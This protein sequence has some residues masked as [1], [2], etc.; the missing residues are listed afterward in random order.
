MEYLQS[1][2][3]IRTGRAEI[4]D[5]IAQYENI[6][7]LEY[8]AMGSSGWSPPAK[9][10]QKLSTVI[11][12]IDNHKYGSIL[13]FE[14]LRKKLLEKVTKLGL[15]IDDLEIMITCGANQAFVN[16]ILCL[17]DNDDKAVLLA[18]YYFSHKLALQ[19]AGVQVHVCPFIKSSLL[20]DMN[21][22]EIILKEQ[23][24]KVCVLTNPN[25]PSG[26]V[27]DKEFLQQFITLCKK[28]NTWIVADSTYFE[29]VYED[30]YVKHIWPCSKIFDYEKIIHHSSFSKNFAM[31]GWRVGFM[32]FPKFL[33]DDMRKIQDT[34][35]T[36]TSIFSE[37]LA[38]FALEVDEEALLKE[39]KSWV[40]SK[41]EGLETIRAELW[42][43]L[44]PYG[45]I[46]PSGSFYY[47]VPI[48]GIV[49]E[50]KAVDILAHQFKILVMPGKVFGAPGYLRVSFGSAKSTAVK[51]L[52]QGLKY[53]KDLTM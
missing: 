13:G 7:D 32:L 37:K 9:A 14:P 16:S 30:S 52:E 40:K 20:P 5:I 21:Q 11:N 3:V 45:V 8:L 44:A 28:Y 24:P 1:Q 10:I 51:K 18:P 15:N 19:L 26:V 27:F 39:G 31:P 33:R 12:D 6:D 38:Y 41:V 36:H 43:V 50:L 17:C 22:L 42:N 34:I 29:F 48:P 4:D 23:H 53:I 46:K 25:N 49:D 47:L 2:R 35:P